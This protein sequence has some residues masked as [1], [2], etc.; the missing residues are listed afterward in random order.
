VVTPVSVLRPPR[1]SFTLEAS[2]LQRTLFGDVF[3]V[4]ASFEPI[5]S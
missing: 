2:L 1:N 5:D 4:G 3:Q